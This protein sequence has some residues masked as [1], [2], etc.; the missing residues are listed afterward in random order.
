MG[1]ALGAYCALL[2]WRHPPIRAM[3]GP[4]LAPGGAPL[5]APERLPANPDF[6]RVA[7]AASDRRAR[8]TVRMTLHLRGVPPAW[9]TETAGVAIFPADA[10]SG[11]SWLPLATASEQAGTLVLQHTLPRGGEVVATLATARAFALHSYL[12][13]SVALVADG[14][15]IELDATAAPVSFRLPHGAQRIGPLRIARVDD[16]SWVAMDVAAT[17][18]DLAAGT[19]R[20]LWL[21]R[22]TYELCDPLQP[23]RR[24]RFDVPADRAVE[25]SASLATGRADRP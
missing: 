6:D 1:V 8:E 9:R 15:T 7:L 11:L 23:E 22:G 4:S 24:Q 12:A 3:E 16:P 19:P 10:T 17:G 2:A 14:G 25:L 5:A 18:L 21:G 20:E 13:R